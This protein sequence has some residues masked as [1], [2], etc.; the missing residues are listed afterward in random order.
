MKTIAAFIFISLYL[1][2]ALPAVSCESAVP[3]TGCD[4]YFDTATGHRYVKV[5]DHTYAEYSR[6]GK[7]LRSDVPATQ[8]HLAKSRHIRTIGPNTYILYEKYQNSRKLQL[9]LHADQPHP[10]GWKSESIFY[11]ANPVLTSR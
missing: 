2:T 6:R 1:A 4:A 11:S 8:P 3:R 7:L 10:Q 5:S 9:V